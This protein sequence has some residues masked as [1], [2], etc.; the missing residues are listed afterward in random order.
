MGSWSRILARNWPKSR[1]KGSRR[2]FLPQ[3]GVKLTSWI[4]VKQAY[5][6]KKPVLAKNGPKSEHFRQKCEILGTI[7]DPVKNRVFSLK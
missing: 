3:N 5:T 7:L 4:P 2:S 6:S 1:E